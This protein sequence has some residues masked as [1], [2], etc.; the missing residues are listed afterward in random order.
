[1][2]ALI[3]LAAVMAMNT[4]DDRIDLAEFARVVQYSGDKPE[5]IEARE[6]ERGV[7][8]WSAWLGPDGQ[9][10]IGV[11]WDEPRDLAEVN[12]EFRHAVANRDQIKVQYWQNH[13]PSDGK[14]GW[15]PLDDPFHGKWVTAKADWWAGDRDVSFAFVPY[16]QEQPGQNAPN[17]RYRRTYRLRFLCGKGEPPPVRYLRAYGPAGPREEVFDIRLD[18][19]S[20]LAAPLAISVVN[21]YVLSEDGQAT[22]LTARLS[23]S[24]AHLQVRFADGDLDTKTRTI[25]TVRDSRDSTEGF[26]F[27]PAEAVKYGIIRIPSLGVVI[28][29]RGSTVDLQAGLHPGMAVFDRVTS[30]PEQTWERARREIPALS[31]FKHSGGP[32][33]L[34]LGPPDARQEIAVRCDAA[35]LLDKSALKC[36]AADSKRVHW[37]ADRWLIRLGSGE[38]PFD[39]ETEGNIKQ[40]LLDNYLPIV[41]NTWQAGGIAYKQTSVAGLLDERHGELRGDE[42]VVLMSRLEMTNTGA[43]AAE[44]VARFWN[45]PNEALIVDQGDVLARGLIKDGRLQAYDK[46]RYRYRLSGAAEGLSTAAA[47]GGAA[48]AMILFRK[49]LV[50]GESRSLVLA[51]PFVTIDTDVERRQMSD[52]DF[53]RLLEHEATR[54][55]RI[56]EKAARIEVPNQLLT[57]FYRAQL[58]HVLITADRDPFNGT[59]VLPAGTFVYNVCLNESCHQIRSLEVRGLH[60]EAEEF[61]D[62]IVKGQSSRGLHGRFTDKKGVLHGLP[63]RNGDYQHFNYN[64]DHGFAL[65]MLNEHYRFTRDKEWLAKVADALVEACDFVTRQRKTAPEANTLGKEDTLWG[66]GLLPPGHLEDPPEWLWWYAVN[67]YAYRGMRLTAE[68][69]AEVGHPQAARIARD[70]EAYGR[71]LR[72]SC[73]ESMI[74]APVQRQRDGTY[75]PHQP[76][77]SRLRGRDL[78][79]IRDAL[80][81]P[82]HLMDCGVYPDDSREAEWILRDTEDNVFIGAAR[83]RA[84]TDYDTQWF[85]WGGITLQSNLLPNP[86]V[87]LRRGQS[88]HAIRAFFNSLAANV[89]EDVRTFCEHPIQAYG[90]GTG[91]F[92]KPPDESA[93]VVWLRCLLVLEQGDDLHLLAGCPAAWLEP[94]KQI[95]VE[96][97]AT[98]FGP[99]DMLVTSRDNPRQISVEWTPPPRAPR[100]IKLHMRLGVPIKSVSLNG[101][102]FTQFDAN[103][104]MVTLPASAG[105]ATILVSYRDAP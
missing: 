22:M 31:K 101:Q 96:R 60:E 17:V 78:G 67:A 33:Y 48:D 86:L 41:I 91:P 37:P 43:Q 66:A 5:N 63:T 88:K 50:P 28:A 83:G 15:A 10:M 104:G 1:V 81:G 73:R 72:D 79:W 54:W 68:S 51:V 89:Y 99:L 34:P 70:A 36:E 97:A 40:Q 44:A 64:L 2:N 27:L 82:V 20:R 29:H 105:R 56:I 30:E 93:F 80:Y 26:S 92:Y 18:P 100:Q 76:T 8:G 77:R 35:I 24:P 42:T 9:Y 3:V 58:A 84:L 74:R 19:G 85:S 25:L 38:P 98:W 69:L 13:W 52:L 61:L 21:G 71:Q 45:E 46:P 90:L 75:L 7:D 57:D 62:A 39:H 94:G 87:Y 102:A 14:G 95:R 65:W 16:D 49:Q 11:E 6:L 47:P 12:I 59:R 4:T 55:R 103:T 32:M 23:T 53:D